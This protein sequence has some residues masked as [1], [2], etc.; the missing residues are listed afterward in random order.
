MKLNIEIKYCS[1]KI[2]LM[3]INGCYK[4]ILS[5]IVTAG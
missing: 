4:R 5:N 3:L 1:Q 2:L